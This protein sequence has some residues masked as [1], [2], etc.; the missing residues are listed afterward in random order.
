MSTLKQEAT[1]D[2]SKSWQTTLFT[3]APR[4]AHLHHH[5]ITTTTTSPLH[6]TAALSRPPT[7]SCLSGF[8]VRPN[9]L[10]STNYTSPTPTNQNTAAME[11]KHASLPFLRCPLS[12]IIAVTNPSS[13][14]R[15]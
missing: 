8:A 3:A 7:T 2:Q 10:N 5:L 4:S 9:R 11:G 6:T 13:T 15:R 14:I 1:L 12:V